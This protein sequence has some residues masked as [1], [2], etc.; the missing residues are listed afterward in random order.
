MDCAI[1]FLYTFLAFSTILL[2]RNGVGEFDFYFII[3]LCF[4]IISY[5]S[6]NEKCAPVLTSMD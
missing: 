5:V 4:K 1:I 2:T 3:G 6:V